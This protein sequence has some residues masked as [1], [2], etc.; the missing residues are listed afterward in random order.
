M[1]GGRGLFC[2]VITVHPHVQT[3]LTGSVNTAANRRSLYDEA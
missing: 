1:Q 3:P 2:R